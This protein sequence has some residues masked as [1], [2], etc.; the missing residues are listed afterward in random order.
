MELLVCSAGG[1]T[2][3]LGFVDIADPVRVT[4]ALGELRDVMLANVNGAAGRVVPAQVTGMTPNP[5]ALRLAT[6]G[7]LPD[8]APVQ[9]E[10]MFFVKGL[11]VY[12][13]TVIGTAPAPQVI[14]TFFGGLKFPS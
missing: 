2:F 12:Q 14:E 3:A 10:A 4:P 11:R 5:Q 1:S 13:A 8:G 9:A 6:S 7:R